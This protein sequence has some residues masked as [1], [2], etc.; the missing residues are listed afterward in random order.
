MSFLGYVA[1]LYYIFIYVLNLT[2]I[3]CILIVLRNI[4]K[5]GEIKHVVEFS[6]VAHW[7]IY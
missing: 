7:I 4:K 3:F 5:V 6:S 2:S 1:I